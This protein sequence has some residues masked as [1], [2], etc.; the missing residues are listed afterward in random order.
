L[1]DR[2]QIVF[3]KR[4][5][6]PK[7]TQT[8]P[9]TLLHLNETYRWAADS[10]THFN[11]TLHCPEITACIN[12]FLSSAFSPNLPDINLAVNKLNEIYHKA[13][14]KENLCKIKNCS[15]W[16]PQKEKWFDAECNLIRNK[17][18]SLSNRKHH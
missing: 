13:A 6:H 1:S 2:C 10:A 8:E 5:C 17:L 4:L 11:T 18:R 12:D 15:N 9:C 7:T 3:S 16:K 14:T